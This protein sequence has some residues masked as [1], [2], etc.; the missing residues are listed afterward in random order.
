[1][2]FDLRLVAADPEWAEWAEWGGPLEFSFE[3]ALAELDCCVDPKSLEDL[4]TLCML[5]L[6]TL[7]LLALLT[8]ALPPG[9][10]MF[11]PIPPGVRPIMLAFDLRG[12][13]SAKLLFGAFCSVFAEFDKNEFSELVLLHGE[14]TIKELH[15]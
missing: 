15:I 3:P 12:L 2:D 4:R 8:L 10:M 11:G 5:L 6:D 1:M 13:L 9:V 7:T 14:S